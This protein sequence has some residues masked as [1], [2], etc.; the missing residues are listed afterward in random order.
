RPDPGNGRQALCLAPS[1]SLLRCRHRAARG[2]SP[3][4]WDGVPPAR[5]GWI[6]AV[7]AGRPRPP[8]GRAAPRGTALPA[9]RR[10]VLERLRL[11]GLGRRSDGDL[12][13]RLA[14]AELGR[15]EPGADTR[16]L[17]DEALVGLSRR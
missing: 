1:G 2:E 10:G 5:H 9:T 12:V 6:R 13:D 8:A 11:A 17:V 3:T 16:R 7:R 14:S 15:V 4:T